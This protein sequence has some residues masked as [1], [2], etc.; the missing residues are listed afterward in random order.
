MRAT[1][2]QSPQ[3][4]SRRYLRTPERYGFVAADLA[5]PKAFTLLT[6][7]DVTGSMLVPHY[8]GYIPTDRLETSKVFKV[9][10]L[11]FDRTFNLGK[12]DRIK[13]RTY[14]RA[15][16]LLDDFQPDLDRGP[17]RDSS[18]FYGPVNMRQIIAG[19]TLTFR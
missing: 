14:L 4:G 19:I 10:D 18:Y 8:A 15:A 6:T 9:L 12:N 5:L 16:N 2:G 13:L 17:L 7:L 1:T 11:V 3:F